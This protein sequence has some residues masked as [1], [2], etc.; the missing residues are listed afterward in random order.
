MLR[1]SPHTGSY[2]HWRTQLRQ[3]SS[4]I[5]LYIFTFYMVI[6]NNK[7]AVIKST[8]TKQQQ[9]TKHPC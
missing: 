9:T 2:L 6:P 5:Y 7:H 1:E 4:L 3:F 8:L